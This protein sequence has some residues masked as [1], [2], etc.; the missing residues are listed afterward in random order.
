MRAPLLALALPALLALPL[1]AQDFSWSGTIARGKTLEIRGINGR[2]H[3]VAARG[4]QARVTATK[5]AR[6]SDPDEV[7]IKAVEHEGGVTI[8]ALYPTRRGGDMECRPHRGQ[9][10]TRDS[11]VEV[12]FEVE[13]P[14]GVTFAGAT[15]N[16]DI[17]ARDLPGDA[18]VSTV[19]GDVEV[20][21]GGV[22]E[23]ATVNGSIDAEMGRLPVE[24]PVSLTTVNGGITLT[25]SGT[26]GM[27]LE[28][29]TVNG[30]VES[31]FPI[32]VSGR[33]RPNSLRGKVGDGGPRV[34]LTTVNGGIQ[35]RKR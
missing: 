20:S 7:V 4:A 2:V 28:A 19:N 6:R 26:P 16:G 21:A 13:V 34:K 10:N 27:D 9:A 22:V 1:A 12:A 30:G 32:T 24:E 15:V 17:S 31:D 33:M 8:C 29:T 25:L 23:A 14:A 18:T 35:L 5:H 11:D 3:A